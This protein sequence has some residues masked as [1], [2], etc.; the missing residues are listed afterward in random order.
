[1]RSL[2][3]TLLTLLAAAATAHAQAPG[4]ILEDP[5]SDS[6]EFIGSAAKPRRL[7]SPEPPRHPFMAPNGRSNIHNDAFQTD[8][9]PGRRAAGPRRRELDP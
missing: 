3:L 5:G 6:P 4:P 9:L 2:S 7:D 1:M 8:S